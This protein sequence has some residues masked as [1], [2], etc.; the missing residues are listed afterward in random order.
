MKSKLLNVGII[1]IVTS[2]SI[3]SCGKSDSG[4]KSLWSKWTAEDGSYLDITTGSFNNPFK[5]TWIT[6]SGV[7]TGELLFIGT[8]SS[9]S[10]ATIWYYD[11]P[12]DNI[13]GYY[14]KSNNTLK[15]CSYTTCI[16][17]H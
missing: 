11:S 17:L 3:I 16:T 10:Y 12:C 2:I 13:T 15:I 14:E 5:I 9:G 7:C 4:E 6:V 8:Q 1:S